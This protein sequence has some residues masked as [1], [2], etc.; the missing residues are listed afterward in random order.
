S[1]GIAYNGGATLSGRIYACGNITLSGSPVTF[2]EDVTC[3]GVIQNK[4]YGIYHKTPIEHASSISIEDSMETAYYR[5]KAQL[6]GLYLG[7]SNATLDLSLFDFSGSTPTYDGTDLGANF[8]GVIFGEKDISVSGVLQGQSLTIVAGD[9]IIITGDVRTG[10]TR[11]HVGGP[12]SLTF[13][14]PTGKELV[15]TVNLNPLM[16]DNVCSAVTMRVS[17][18]KWYRLNL[19]LK[20]DGDSIAVTTLQRPASSPPG[21]ERE[22][23]TVLARRPLDPSSHTYEAEIHY[24]SKGPTS[25]PQSGSGVTHVWVEVSGG[26]PVNVGL[27][28]KDYLYLSATT[29]RI[30]TIDAALFARDANW[31]PID[32]SDSSDRDNSHSPC[33]GV[34]DLDQ[35]GQIE[36]PNEDGYDEANC[37]QNT[38]TLN[39]NGPIITKN[40]GSAGPWSYYGDSQNKGTRHYNYDDDIVYYQPPCFPVILSRWA[41]AYWREM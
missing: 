14:A 25:N 5:Q 6:G 18:P 9:D 2:M 37:D 7:N 31:R 32:Y 4:H 17:G 41:V 34:W 16:D 39:I 36:R 35:D 24:W 3:T 26:E 29:P 1:G 21:V 38:W 23:A 19:Y 40:G 22:E 8:N 20:E 30:L 10:N 28:A 12:V 11:A 33:Y 15:Q 13:N 27:I